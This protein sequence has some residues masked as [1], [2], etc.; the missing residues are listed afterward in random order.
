[1]SLRDKAG[2]SLFAV[3]EAELKTGRANA[4]YEDTRFLSQE[5]EWFFAGVLDGLPDVMPAVSPPPPA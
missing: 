3:S 4:A 1:M 2:K 5:G